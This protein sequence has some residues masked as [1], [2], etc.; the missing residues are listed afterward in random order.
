MTIRI[1]CPACQ[2][3]LS[4]AAEREGARVKCPKC[5]EPFTVRSAESRVKATPP[6]PNA[7]TD[8]A[9]PERDESIAAGPPRGL[10]AETKSKKSSAA[11]LLILLC[12]AGRLGLVLLLGVGA[13]V[14]VWFLRG[15]GGTATA[16]NDGEARNAGPANKL[17]DKQVADKEPQKPVIVEEK[18][19]KPPAQ[20]FNLD[21]SQKGV[22]FL[23]VFVPGFPPT[24]GSGF[25]V[26]SDGLIATNRHV[27]DAEDGLPPGAKIIV[28][29]PRSD[30]AGDFD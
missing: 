22:V 7:R 15:A 18:K 24:S 29:V 13:V 23:R 27:L 12:A 26:T 16:A 6:P 4:C 28:G 5:K 14:A 2:T 11:G 25:F 3:T 17:A 8:P 30:Q 9:R 21:E 10:P 19:A 1:Q 20:R